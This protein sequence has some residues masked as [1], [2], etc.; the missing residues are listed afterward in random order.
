MNDIIVVIMDNIREIGEN[1]NNYECF[2]GSV[3]YDELLSIHSSMRVGGR[4]S[5][6]VEP[7]NESSFLK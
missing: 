6:Y 4:A 5:V 1:I 3:F 7:N 2:D